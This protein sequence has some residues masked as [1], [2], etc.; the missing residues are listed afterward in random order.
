MDNRKE[1]LLELCQ[2]YINDHHITEAGCIG[3]NDD[4]ILDA[5]DLIEEICD[6]LGYYKYPE[7]E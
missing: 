3:Q 5:G 2:K 6:I 1:K 4:I 7:G